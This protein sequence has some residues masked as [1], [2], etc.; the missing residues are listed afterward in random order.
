[1]DNTLVPVPKVVPC[2]K[3][4]GPA[5]CAG[6]IDE[7]PTAVATSEKAAASM[8]KRFMDCGLRGR[9]RIAFTCPGTATGAA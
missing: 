8:R 2:T 6:R 3:A 9:M 5:A 1:V 7:K 4:G